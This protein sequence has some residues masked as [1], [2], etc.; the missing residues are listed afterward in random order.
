MEFEEGGG[1]GGVKRK[2]IGFKWDATRKMPQ[3]TAFLIMQTAYPN[4]IRQRSNIQKIQFSQESMLP[5]PFF[6]MHQKA[7][8][9]N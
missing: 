1:G 3:V 5:T 8:L 6:I 9:P 4:A 7:I 2:N